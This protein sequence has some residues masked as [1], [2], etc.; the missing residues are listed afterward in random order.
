MKT[1]TKPQKASL[2]PNHKMIPHQE[3]QG[4]IFDLDGT[5]YRMR[6]YMRPLLTFKV[7]PKVLRLPRFLK[8]RGK[9]AGREMNSRENLFNTLCEAVSLR[10]K[11]SKEEIYSWIHTSFYPAFVSTMPFFRNSRP[12]LNDMLNKLYKSG[13]KLGVLSDYDHVEQRLQKLQIPTSIFTIMTSAE[14]FGAL[15]PCARPLLEIAD[16]WHLTPAQVLVIGDRDDTDGEAAR[17]AGMNF[18]QIRDSESKNDTAGSWDEVQR[19]CEQITNT[20]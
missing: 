13:I 8:E 11:C 9:F 2:E 6:W 15:K 12:G 5:L 20:K 18:L 14:S 17:S 1:F 7:F 16:K 19:F 10:E 4:I 3:I